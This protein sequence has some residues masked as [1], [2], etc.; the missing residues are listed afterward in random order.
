MEV[1]TWGGGE[2]YLRNSGLPA[3]QQIC[4]WGRKVSLPEITVMGRCVVWAAEG[5]GGKWGGLKD[6]IAEGYQRPI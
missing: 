1:V 4:V 2:D 3:E 6:L 5:W